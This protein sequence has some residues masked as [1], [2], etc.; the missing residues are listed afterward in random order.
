[1]QSLDKLLIK[2]SSKQSLQEKEK[3]QNVDHNQAVLLSLHKLLIKAST[4]QSVS[5]DEEICMNKGDNQRALFWW[6]QAVRDL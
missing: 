5:K 2:A 1:M 3:A 4:K 6:K